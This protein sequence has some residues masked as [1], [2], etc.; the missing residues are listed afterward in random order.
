VSNRRLEILRNV[1]ALRTLGGS[2]GDFLRNVLAPTCRV[3]GGRRIERVEATAEETIA[4]YVVGLKRPLFI[5]AEFDLRFLHQVL[6]EETY[7][8]NW[9]YYQIPQTR[10]ERGD[11]VLDCGA[12]EGFFSL[13]ASEQGAGR[14]ICLEP[15][16]AYLRALR[17]TFNDDENVTIVAA[18]LGDAAGE[19]RLSNDGIASTVTDQ[20]DGTI[21][22]RVETIDHLCSSLQIRPTYIKA[23][24]EGYEEKMLMGAAETIAAH[25]PKLAITTYHRASAGG[26]MEHFL[27]TICPDYNI[28]FKGLSARHGATVMLHAWI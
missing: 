8:W 4:V 5:P 21:P 23:D 18:A 15:H 17:K 14:V 20:E 24:I 9:H 28:R 16:P 25:R 19:I 27:K 13:L 26:W 6:T 3:L 12:A 11:V 7:P 1:V 2:S 22:V 10:V